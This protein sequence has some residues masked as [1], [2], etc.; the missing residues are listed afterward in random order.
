MVGVTKYT[1]PKW[2][3]T[4]VSSKPTFTAG[5]LIIGQMYL[6]MVGKV[7]MECTENGNYAEVEFTKRGW[8]ASSYFKCE[9]V[10]FN[11]QKQQKYKINGDWS[12]EFILINLDT[13]E[14]K[15]IWKKDPYHEKVD[16]MYGFTPFAI[17][18]NNLPEQLKDKLPH[19]DSRF[20][21]D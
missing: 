3:E 9:A 11:A 16:F 14:E 1:L 20:R 19:T 2:K 18:L 7:R 5:N 10:I 21:P 15:V 17:N 12:S 6:D 4:Y 8:S 13:N